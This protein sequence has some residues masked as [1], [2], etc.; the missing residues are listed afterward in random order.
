M[1]KY[2]RIAVTALSLTACV[3]LIALWVRSY[4]WHDGVWGRFSEARGFHLSSHEGR[5][6]LSMLSFLGI[7]EWRIVHAEL[8]DRVGP[9]NY[10]PAF[11]CPL[12]TFGLYAAVPYWI[13]LAVTA[14]FAAGLATKCRFSLR[15][16]LI[17][18]TLVAVGLGI[19]AA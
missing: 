15:T 19:V 8:I 5:V 1:L 2:L 18:T 16:L 11:E 3:L 6:Q 17:A 14:T 10:F 7:V 13:L 9:P 4:T 12:S